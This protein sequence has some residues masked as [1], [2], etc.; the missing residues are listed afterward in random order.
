[1][2]QQ[3]LGDGP[4]LPF[5]THAVFD[6]H[7]DVVEEFL[8]EHVPAI[9]GDDRLHAD[10]GGFQVDQQAG[11]ALLLLAAVVGTHQREHA[12]GAVGIAGPD[13][14]AIDNI[15]V[16]IQHSGGFQ[17]RQIGARAGLA[18]ALAP[19]FFAG[20]DFRQVAGFLLRRAVDEQYRAD[21]ARA[22]MHGARRAAHEKLFLEDVFFGEGETGAAVLR[23]PVR[24]D[25]AGLRQ[26]AHPALE[27]VAAELDAAIHLVL[28]VRRQIFGGE[29]A[30]LGAEGL[31]V[32]GETQ[33]HR[34]PLG[35]T[36]NC[37]RGNPI[38]GW[39]SIAL[40]GS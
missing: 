25:P 10:A 9:Q 13:L 22:E 4:A 31:F 29:G 37:S 32:G 19:D 38:I 11:D 36:V 26:H 28:D 21:H 8:V 16:A 18:I 40:C 3:V 35:Q 34:V 12:V 14:G 17:R 24:R 6:R 7:A 20:Q 2:A 30:D 1:M 39:G 15:V 23:V 33:V 27:V 5:L